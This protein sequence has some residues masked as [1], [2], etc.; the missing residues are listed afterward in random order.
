MMFCRFFFLFLLEG[1]FEEFCC[2]LRI[3][4][5]CACAGPGRSAKFGGLFVM[6][7]KVCGIVG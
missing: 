2:G 6:G 4:I 7:R 3:L 5:M 1:G